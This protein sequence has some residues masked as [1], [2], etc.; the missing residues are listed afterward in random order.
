MEKI[1]YNINAGSAVLIFLTG[2]GAGIALAGLLTPRSG[3]ATRRIIGRRVDEGTGWVKNKA[4]AA[5]DFVRSQADE[6]RDKVKD[7]A[8]VIGRG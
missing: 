2:M 6:L 7:V 5:Q 3:A 4:A 1:E 8:E